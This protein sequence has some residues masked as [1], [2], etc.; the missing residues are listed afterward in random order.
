MAGAVDWVLGFWLL[1]SGLCV[2]SFV[3][4]VV[5]RLPVMLERQWRRE[6]ALLAGPGQAVPKASDGSA[7]AADPVE[8]FNLLR[9]RSRCPSCAR[10]IRAAEN[11]PLL[12]WMLLRGKCAGCGAKIS[13]RYPIVEVLGAGAAG[14]A[15]AMFGFSWLAAAAMIYLW[16]LIALAG[17]DAEQGLLPDQL[18]LPLLWTG[19]LVNLV[20]GLAPLSSAVVGAAAG[21]LS[22]WCLYWAFKLTTG[23]DGMGYGDFKLLAAIGAWLGWQSLPAVALLAA[24]SGLIFAL[25]GIL[26]HRQDRR[27][28]MPFG[29][30]LAAAGWLALLFPAAW[31]GLLGA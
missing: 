25:A 31:G 30:F 19:L 15:V 29:P 4:V 7:Q 9:P 13:L 2:G 18:T 8:P 6:A 22:L 16:T 28:P 24:A 1:V 23:K 27:Q 21:Y 10:Q 12:S 26:L 20:G 3:N 11:I 14:T 5:H 17:I